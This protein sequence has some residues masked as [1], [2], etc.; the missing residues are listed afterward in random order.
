M[1]C[2]CWPLPQPRPPQI[3]A[4]SVTYTIAHGNAGYLTHCAEPG[5]RPTSSWILVG[6][7]TAQPQREL[8]Y[9]TSCLCFLSMFFL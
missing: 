1:S 9:F 2:S 3:Q 8:L 6:F 7:I 4:P 5:I